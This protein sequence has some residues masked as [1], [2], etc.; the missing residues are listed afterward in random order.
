M[1]AG[2]LLPPMEERTPTKGAACSGKLD[3][4][5]VVFKQVGRFQSVD[6][7]PVFFI[8]YLELECLFLAL[9]HF[10]GAIVGRREGWFGGV[11]SD[12]DEGRCFQLP[13]NVHLAG[14][15]VGLAARDETSDVFVELGRRLFVGLAEEVT[16][17]CEAVAVDFRG[18]GQSVV[19]W[20]SSEAQHDPREFCTPIFGGAA[21][22]Q[23]GF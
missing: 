1:A 22:H 20:S 19:F 15:V 23:R 7:Y 2:T 14:W 4:W 9:E 21:G 6:G 3:I 12:E 16:R 10:V 8:S 17:N 5:N 13:W 18:G 11:D